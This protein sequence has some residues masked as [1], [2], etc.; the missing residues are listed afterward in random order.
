MFRK[1]EKPTA[2][3]VG[4]INDQILGD[5]NA[6]MVT[7][8]VSVR[9]NCTSVKRR[10]MMATNLPYG[11]NARKGAVRIQGLPGLDG[12]EYTLD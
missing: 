11:D 2:A 12:F 6:I 7:C 10:Q 4:I 3:T 1:I 9:L 5:G 8:S